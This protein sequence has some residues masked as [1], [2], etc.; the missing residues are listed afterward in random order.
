MN[1][2]FLKNAMIAFMFVTCTGSLLVAC[3]GDDDGEKVDKTALTALITECEGIASNAST[4]DYPQSAIDAFSTVIGT[5]KTASATASIKQTEVD[6]LVTQLTEAKNIFLDAAYA[7]I[8]AS[9][10]L[11]GL[12]FDEGQ[13]T[14]LTAT[15]KNLIAKLQAGPTE[16]FGTDTN[17]PTFV[18]GKKG[19]AMYFNNGSHLAI[20]T[21]SANDFLGKKMSVSVWVKPEDTRPGNYIMSYNYWNSWKF[22][23][24]ENNKPFFTVRTDVGWTDAD[25]E[26]D[27]SAPNNAWT[28]LVVALDLDNE[29]LDFYVNG[30]LTKRWDSETKPNIKG[31]IFNYD[32]N[33]PV[34]IGACTTYAEADAEWD[35]DWAR[36]PASWDWF[37]GAM[38]EL[39]VY[40][41]ALTQG[42]VTRLYETEK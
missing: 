42:Q 21:F 27:F 1:S 37:Y 5:V 10:L 13:G 36:E 33:L 40:N 12:S 35:W 11:L 20:E 28:H 26:A 9:A 34:L 30:F 4:G 24:Q 7:D 41:I 22:Q 32:N 2:N 16:I 15:G 14:Q 23:L 6:N 17:L 3:N 8:P 31:S 38:D 39:K 19:T 29:T 25:N 18:D